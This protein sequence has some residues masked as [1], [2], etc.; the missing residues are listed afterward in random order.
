MNEGGPGQGSMPTTQAFLPPPPPLPH[1]YKDSIDRRYA[2]ET[3]PLL[4]DLDLEVN[5]MSEY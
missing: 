4:N 1:P 5:L 3:R 2:K